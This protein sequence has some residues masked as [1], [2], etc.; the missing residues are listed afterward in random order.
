MKEGIDGKH[1]GAIFLSTVGTHL[2]IS[3]SAHFEEVFGS[4]SVCIFRVCAL[5]CLGLF[6]SLLH[7]SPSFPISIT[8]L[9]F[10]PFQTLP[11]KNISPSVFPHDLCSSLVDTYSEFH[12]GFE[13]NSCSVV[14]KGNVLCHYKEKL[15]LCN[16]RAM[17]G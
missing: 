9:P 13:F 2:G 1:E 15:S 7:L 5:L 4:K 17:R 14:S 6:A 16:D 12:T 8:F 11:R 10:P 3:N